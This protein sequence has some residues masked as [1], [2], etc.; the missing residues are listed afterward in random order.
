MHIL[1]N[2]LSHYNRPTEPS[3]SQPI[4]KA[5]IALSVCSALGSFAA[6][7]MIMTAVLRPAKPLAEPVNTLS[8]DHRLTPHVSELQQVS[9]LDMYPGLT[10]EDARQI[11]LSTLISQIHEIDESKVIFY[12]DTR[13][14]GNAIQ[15]FALVFGTAIQ[16]GR[17]PATYLAPPASEPNFE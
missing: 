9:D 2:K 11:A 10:L 15:Q 16:E 7:G 17:D 5:L 4:G 3:S 6:T 13:R 14:P 8:R 1:K 12:Q